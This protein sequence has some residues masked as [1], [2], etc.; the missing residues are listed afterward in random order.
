MKSD[1]TPCIIYADL[2]YSI[3]KMDGW[4]NDPEKS[5]ITKIGEHIP[6][7]HSMSII[8]GSDH[9]KEKHTLYLGKDCMKKFWESLIDFQ[10]EKNLPLTRKKLK[11][12]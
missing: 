12:H 9:I 6:R 2:E 4:A 1:K 5:S 8:G 3:K 10:K 11:S 7:G